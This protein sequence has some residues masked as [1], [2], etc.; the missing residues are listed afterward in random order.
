MDELLRNLKITINDNVYLKDPES[1]SLGRRI[2]EHGILLINDLG[3][4]NFTFKKLGE[5]IESN[6]SSVYRY[7]ENKHKFLIYLTNWYWGWKEYQLAFATANIHDPKEKLEQAIEILTREVEEDHSFNHINEVALN[8]IVINEYS[9]SY[10]TKEVDDENKEGYFVIYKRLTT[11][12]KEMIADVNEGYPYPAS[13]ASTILA[14]SLHQHFLKDHFTSLTDCSK[15]T[16]PS[17]YFIH[18]TSNLLN[19]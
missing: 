15:K 10:L 12:L 8:K 7:F 6:E 19:S 16:S 9:K 13:L 18:L 5:R 3:F 17:Q 4:D 1:S 2:V 11:R 14:G